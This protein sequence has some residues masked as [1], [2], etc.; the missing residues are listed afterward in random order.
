ML[1][2][3]DCVREGQHRARIS[4]S[5]LQQLPL[6]RHAAN[7][8]VHTPKHLG[9]VDPAIVLACEKPTSAFVRKPFPARATV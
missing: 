9:F 2:V 1:C 5:D 6:R 3:L 4:G 7:C 8:H